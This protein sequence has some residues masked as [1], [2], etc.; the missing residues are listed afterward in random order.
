[1]KLKIFVLLLF[2]TLQGYSQVSVSAKHIGKSSKFKK[3]VLEKFK[4]TETIFLLSGIY[5]K[6]E[7]DKILKTSWNVTPYKIVDSENFEIEDYISDK[8]SIAQLAGFKR[9]KQMKY[10]GTSTSLFTYVDI[11]IYDS[12]EIFKKLN[13]LSPK[14][15]AKKKNDIINDNSSNIARFYIFTKDDFIHTSLSKDMNTIVNSLYNDDVFFNYKLG[16]LQN[17]FQKINNLLKEE[18][19]YWMYEDD[20]LPELKKLA[21]KKLY[22]PSYMTIKYNG[23]TGQDS[24]EDDENIED[25]FKK[26]DYKYEII[27]DEEL[28]NKILNNEE[29]YYLRYVRMNAERFL[30]V[31]NSKTGEIIYRNYI[32]GLS[33]KIK[34]KHIK[35]LNGKIKKA[36]K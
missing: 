4:N 26:Y 7:Y 29:L 19:I 22:I 20:F 34:S 31:V 25:I 32:T 15:R 36:S 28:N 3:G 33:Y 14:K 2:I 16:F 17:Y 18:Q 11:K 13:K 8:Y 30:Q 10:G 24:E 23:W 21:S 6:S 5:D 9:I 35:E 27:S 12:E 1:M